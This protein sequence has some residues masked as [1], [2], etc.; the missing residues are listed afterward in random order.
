MKNLTPAQ[1]IYL[2]VLLGLIVAWLGLELGAVLYEYS[3]GKSPFTALL[4]QLAD[5]MK[6]AIP[7]VAALTWM[8]QRTGVLPTPQAAD[9]SLR[10]SAGPMNRLRNLALWIVI[11]LL[12]VLLFNLFQGSK[13]HAP[14]SGDPVAILVE[15]FP[16]LLVVVVWVYFLLRFQAKKNRDLSG[17]S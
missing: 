2:G 17:K 11:A 3:H 4:L 13:G 12:L 10:A 14:Q 16:L 1:K 5:I 9:P 6:F 8:L 7:G 15:W